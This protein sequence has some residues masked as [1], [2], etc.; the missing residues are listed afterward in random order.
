MAEIEWDEDDDIGFNPEDFDDDDITDLDQ[1]WEYADY[2]EE[3][4]YEYEFH[5]TGDT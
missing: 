4:L 2:Y 1:L 3:D 5:G